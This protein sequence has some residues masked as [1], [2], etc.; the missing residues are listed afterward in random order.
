[1]HGYHA[2]MAM[3]PLDAGRPHGPTV[4]LFRRRRDRLSLVFH[5]NDHVK[6][7]LLRPRAPD[8]ALAMAAQ[9]MRRIERFERRCGL[10]V[11]RVMTPPHGLCSESVTQ[12]LAAVGFDALCA[13]HPIPWTGAPPS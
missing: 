6:Q 9:A 13:I 8:D 11:D 2:S 4:S 10:P 12:A 5:G 1:M 7:E 3:I